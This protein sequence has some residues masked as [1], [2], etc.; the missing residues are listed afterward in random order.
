[1]KPFHQFLRS[2]FEGGDAE[3]AG[4]GCE[5]ANACC[6]DGE[7]GAREDDI[8]TR[9]LFC[10]QLRGNKEIEVV[11]SATK[12]MKSVESKREG[13]RGSKRLF[14]ARA[15]EKQNNDSAS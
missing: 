1:M 10:R 6:V 15:A 7:S 4:V 11:R 8:L 14:S 9:Q 13:F 3:S 12:P 5:E 2:L